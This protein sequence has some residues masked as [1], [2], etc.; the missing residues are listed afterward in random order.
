MQSPSR[1]HFQS[2]RGSP[3]VLPRRFVSYLPINLSG[4]HIWSFALPFH[5]SGRAEQSSAESPFAGIWGMT[6]GRLQDPGDRENRF[7]TPPSLGLA[8]WCVTTR[9]TAHTH[10]NGARHPRATNAPTPTQ[11][12]NL[13]FFLSFA[14]CWDVGFQWFSS[15][16]GVFQSFVTIFSYFHLHTYTHTIAGRTHSVHYIKIIKGLSI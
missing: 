11:S 10:T 16:S 9:T 3:S 14:L 15:H 7:F 4:R 13:P 1:S 6:R 2:V 5:T 12:V 8:L